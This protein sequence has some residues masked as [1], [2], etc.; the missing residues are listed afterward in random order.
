MEKIDRALRMAGGGENG[1]LVA[2]K[3]V[4]PRVN[5]SGV[6]FP[7]LWRQAEIG[8]EKGRSKFGHNFFERISGVA[9]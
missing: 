3:C 9:P 2:L 7:R 8:A 6:V 4:D 5:I 1:T